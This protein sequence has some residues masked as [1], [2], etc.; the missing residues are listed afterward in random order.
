MAVDPSQRRYAA[1]YA[2]EKIG[3]AGQ[4]RINAAKVMLVG[5]GGLGCAAAQYLAGSGIAELHICD[6]DTVSE[7]NLARQ[8][9]YAPADVG[10]DKCEAAC[11]A[12]ERINPQV[13]VRIH[14]IRADQ[15][16]LEGIGPGL[17]LLIDA[18]DNYGTRLAVN[19]SSLKSGLPWV[20]GS[21]IRME[22]Q[23]ML[24]NPRD[25]DYPCYRCVYG[26]A[27]DSLEDCPGAGV[28]AP[29]AGIIGTSMAHMGL[30]WLA[31]LSPPKG[32]N[33][34]D[35]RDLNWHRLSVSKNPQCPDCS[36]AA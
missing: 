24:F 3:E 11:E 15:S 18:S 13:S 35:A 21:C 4:N 30:S 16:F 33:L 32:L 27:P 20:M 17:D 9:L 31:G 26:E 22:G 12:L 8:L 25:N 19:R 23:L 28:F 10:R 5:L 14:N 34:L 7:S 1:H 2:L 29:V 6:F 36:Q